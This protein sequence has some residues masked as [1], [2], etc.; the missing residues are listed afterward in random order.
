MKLNINLYFYCNEINVVLFLLCL[1][2]YFI[3]FVY[4]FCDCD[5]HYVCKQQDKKATNEYDKQQRIY[6]YINVKASQKNEKAVIKKRRLSLQNN[7]NVNDKV[8]TND[9]TDTVQSNDNEEINQEVDLV[10]DISIS[11]CD[12]VVDSGVDAFQA[13]DYSVIEEV[14][15]SHRV[16]AEQISTLDDNNINE[17]HINDANSEIEH[18]TDV[19]VEQKVKNINEDTANVSQ[20]GNCVSLAEFY[21]TCN[22]N[23]NNFVESK[24]TV[25]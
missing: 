4:K 11:V 22:I 1:Q 14:A 17:E 12:A 2:Q 9:N 19:Q 24:N 18:D 21:E 13:G 7:L 6:W 16:T 5:L 25:A 3:V 15:D 8:N 10:V 20:C 23:I